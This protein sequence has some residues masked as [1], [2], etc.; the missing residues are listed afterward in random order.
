MC[1]SHSNRRCM[2]HVSRTESSDAITP[3]AD[4]A[5][6]V[7]K[8]ILYDVLI[9]AIEIDVRL[10][11]VYRLFCFFE[12]DPSLM[13]NVILQNATRSLLDTPRVCYSPDVRKTTLTVTSRYTHTT[14]FIYMDHILSSIADVTRDD[15]SKLNAADAQRT[16]INTR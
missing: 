5:E 2:P 13:D 12:V 9:R 10:I 7:A 6:N 3:V 14:S 1:V 11:N 4:N 15:I 16:S 8:Q